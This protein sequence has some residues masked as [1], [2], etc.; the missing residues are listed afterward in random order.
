MRGDIHI[1]Y[2]FIYFFYFCMNTCCRYSLKVP[3][4]GATNN[5][6]NISFYAEI[7]HGCSLE[8]PA[9]RKCGQTNAQ[10]DGRTDR[11]KMTHIRTWP[12]CYPDKH[13]GQVF[14]SKVFL[15]SQHI[16]SVDRQMD[17]QTDPR[18]LIF[19]HY[20][21]HSDQVWKFSVTRKVFKSSDGQTDS[22]MDRRCDNYIFQ[23]GGPNYYA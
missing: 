17:G 2:L 11:S 21:K 9:Q 14:C 4:W 22:L 13:S 23:C 6:H 12:R 10:T 3:H 20:Y 19:E 15:L 1:Y 5:I 18:W 7:C 8:V 16:E